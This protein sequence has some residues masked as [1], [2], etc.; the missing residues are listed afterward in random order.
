M[1]LLII[2]GTRYFGK[3]F[4]QLMLD[5][6][7]SVSVLT[8]GNSQD[9]FGN[10][11]TRLIADRTDKI[12]LN[13]VIKSD[14][15]VVVDN[16]LMN[17][18]EADD[19]ISILRNRIGHY[20]MTSTLSVYDPTTGAIFEND[21]EA[22]QYV[23]NSNSAFQY[24]EGK[25][26]AEHVL[27]SAPFSV[28]VMRIPVIVGPDDYTKRL[29]THV[30]AVKENTK[31]YFPNPDAKFSFL[32]SQD[33]ARALMW[34]STQKPKD[35]FN[36]SAPNAWT[37]R[38][39]MSCIESRTGKKFTYGDESDA[40]SPFGVSDDY[41]MNVDKAKNAGF[42]VTKLDDWMPTLIDELA[43]S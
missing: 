23:P 30:K 13:T 32:H 19:A 24:Q 25:R 29:L 5:Q 3:R 43:K 35:T 39:L 20:V 11:V 36:I 6:G 16:M 34:L 2:G 10:K 22:S 7:H 31:L 1:K 40:P 14:Y 4:V 26:A 8:R 18:K 27:L 38:E 28:S 42:N 37:L 15:D 12:Q 21:F 41:F 9:S 17:S 33:A